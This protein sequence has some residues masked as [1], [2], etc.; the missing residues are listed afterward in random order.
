MVISLP[1]PLV[2]ELVVS[3]YNVSNSLT[4]IEVETDAT[5]VLTLLEKLQ[6]IWYSLVL[7][8]RQLLKKLGTPV[9]RH[10]FRKGNKVADYLADQGSKLGSYN[11]LST[12]TTPTLVL[13]EKIEADKKGVAARR[14][15]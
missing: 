11:L 5:E 7:S 8:C 6:P 15:L 14:Y 13:L 9:V 4:P 12:I 2:V 10:S 1:P 3:L